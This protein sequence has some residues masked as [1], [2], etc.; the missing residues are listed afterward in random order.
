MSTVSGGSSFVEETLSTSDFTS[1]T[2]TTT[3]STS[4][5][6]TTSYRYTL[7]STVT[8][9][10]TGNDS[11]PVSKGST[12]PFTYSDD[13]T[14]SRDFMEETQPKPS[15][16]QRPKIYTVY[17]LTSKYDRKLIEMDLKYKVKFL[18]C[19]WFLTLFRT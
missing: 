7:E 11:S 9:G 13:F 16:S 10:E 17:P 14:T 1:E 4:G 19:F 15:I 6:E 3:E 8:N 18:V 2:L 5:T 12:G